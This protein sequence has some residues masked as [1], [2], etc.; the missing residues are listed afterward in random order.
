M[1]YVTAKKC[2]ID[3]VG[4]VSPISDPPTFNLNTGLLNLTDQLQIR[5]R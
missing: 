5:Y 1:S 2:F 4:L 3:N